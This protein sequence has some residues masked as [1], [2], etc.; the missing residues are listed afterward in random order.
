MPVYF[1][2]S[3][4]PAG[5]K[6]VG[7]TTSGSGNAATA[8]GAGNIQLGGST[9]VAR[10]ALRKT[11]FQDR[12]QTRRYAGIG[13]SIMIYA[14]NLFLLASGYAAGKYKFVKNAGVAGNT[15]AMLLARV[16][17]DVP[18]NVTD[19]YVM[20]GTNDAS[21]D[22]AVSVSRSNW[23]GIIE[24]LLDR[25]IRPNVVLPP[26]MNTA[27]KQLLIDQLRFTEWL[28][29]EDYGI[30]VLDPWKAFRAT[31]GT[32]A[33]G[34]AS[35]ELH[36]TAATHQ[37]AGVELARQQK[38]DLRASP[39]PTMN[40]G[41]YGYLTNALL[42]TASAGLASGWS[43]SGN[44][45]FTVG[46]DAAVLGQYQQMVAAGNATV[47]AYR[48]I[49]TG[50]AV[51]DEIC[52]TALAQ[53]SGLTT[54]VARVYVRFTG[55]VGETDLSCIWSTSDFTWTQNHARCLIPAGTTKLTV[56]CEIAAFGSGATVASG[57]LQF[58]ETQVY[59]VTQAL[60][61]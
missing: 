51:G 8:S 54:G 55:A 10:A 57:T 36:P 45:T 1:P 12:I 60:A 20:E 17:T 35:D 2:G 29:A 5:V 21:N 15:S 49:T 11:L 34:A 30:P 38:S 43:K 25:G 41:G 48:D 18:D 42:M 27:G 47:F 39:S 23:R 24:N 32:Y 31:D 14:T 13:N 59:N 50:F 37:L 16:A 7:Y 6:P 3:G 53:A 40:T 46:T 9:S 4:L 52:I 28:L 33:S 19:C 22:I 44:G 58:G 56:Y 26:P 61:L